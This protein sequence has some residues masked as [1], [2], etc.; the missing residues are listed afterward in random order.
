MCFSSWRQL[1]LKVKGIVSV[2]VLWFK[3]CSTSHQRR[4]NNRRRRSVR[5]F[6]LQQ[7][8][9]PDIQNQMF[10]TLQL[11]VSESAVAVETMDSVQP[12]PTDPVTPQTA[13]LTPGGPERREET[14]TAE[15]VAFV[16]RGV[17]QETVTW[18]RFI[19]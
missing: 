3:P 10:P 8:R 5:Y 6:T 9:R 7:L 2:V 18:K 14:Q 16:L 13:D 4:R 17:L 19:L 15:Q 11:P 12:V 1:W